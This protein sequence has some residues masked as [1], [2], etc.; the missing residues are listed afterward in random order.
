M[1]EHDRRKLRNPPIKSRCGLWP[2]R[3]AP[4]RSEVPGLA[5][6]QVTLDLSHIPFLS[7]SSWFFPGEGSILAQNSLNTLRRP[8][9]G[10]LGW[11]MSYGPSPAPENGDASTPLRSSETDAH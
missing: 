6:S 8:A 5:D 4:S 3:S 9:E 1:M 11:P 7:R 2:G 10:V